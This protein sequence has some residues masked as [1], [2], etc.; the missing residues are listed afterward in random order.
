MRSICT[1][2]TLVELDKVT[3]SAIKSSRG[4][5][6]S[7]M[8][9][10]T[11]VR[12][13][14]APPWDGNPVWIHGDLLKSNLLVQNGR[15]CAIIDFGGVGIGDPAADVVPAWSVFNKVGREIFRQALGVDDDTWNRACGYA[16]HQALMIIPYYP[17]TNPEF[18][19][20]AKRTVE[21]I[22]TELN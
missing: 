12:S 22:L 10:T 3:R 2:L 15:L 17:K 4:V 19:T 14:E 1:K 18:V 21:E 13:L 8:A 20:M 16:L 7:E 6:D 5:I 9:S 11:W